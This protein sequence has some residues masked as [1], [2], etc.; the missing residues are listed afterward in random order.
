MKKNKLLFINPNQ[1]G[2][3]AGY[4]HYCIQLKEDYEIIFITFDQN[5][6]KIELPGIQVIYLPYD[7]NKIRRLILFFRKIFYLCST[8]QI[9]IL[10]T[11]YF[12]YCFLLSIFAKSKIKVLDIRSG[13]LARFGNLFIWIQSLFF[14]HICILSEGLRIKLRIR[15][16]K[17]LILSLG[18]DIYFNGGHDFSELCLLYVGSLNFRNIDQT[19]EGLAIFLNQNENYRNKVHYFII[20]FGNSDEVNKLFIK[21]EKWNIQG[22]ITFV[23]QKRYME[24][25]PYFEKC[26]IGVAYVPMNDFYEYQPTTKIFEYVLSGLYCV[27]TNTFENRRL[28]NEKNGVLCE[29]TPSGFANALKIISDKHN[30]INSAEVRETLKDYEWKYIINYSLKPYLDN[31][32]KD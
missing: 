10:F 31:L 32:L 28:I 2:Y 18:S 21:I 7:L 16:R 3:S 27:A 30:K 5:L 12:K 15:N 11:V 23:G 26:N 19:I 24:L 13:E 1:F 9:N 20:G 22:N 25:A 4:F 6:P 29:D 14:R 8:N 17:S